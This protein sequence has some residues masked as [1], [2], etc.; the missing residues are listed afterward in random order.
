MKKTLFYSM[1]LT[2]VFALGHLSA[3]LLDGVAHAQTTPT[4]EKAAYLIASSKLVLVKPAPERAAAYREAALPLALEAGMQQLA[5]GQ[6]GRTTLQVLE[7]QWP[8]EGGVAIEKFRSMK[9]LLDFWNSPGY[10]K[11]RKL[12]EE[13][14]F[15]IAVEARE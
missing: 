4:T 12:R 8:Y 7:G 1:S 6:S 2:A 3:H 15:I 13:A 9:A 10:Q 5:S 14:N 11:A